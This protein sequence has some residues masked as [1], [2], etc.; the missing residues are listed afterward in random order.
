[1]LKGRSPCGRIERIT[2]SQSCYE[3]KLNPQ[4]FGNM[5]KN[6][7]PVVI[8]YN[9][10]DHFV[11][12]I[13]ATESDYLAFKIHKEFGSLAAATLLVSKELD[14][15]TV[16][17]GAAW[18]IKAI[19]KAL[20]ENLPKIS[21]KA[22]NYYKQLM[23]NTSIYHGPDVQEA[24]AVPHTS[25]QSSS[26]SHQ[27]S[28]SSTLP[29]GAEV[30]EDEDTEQQGSTKGYKCAECGKVCGRKPDLRGHLWS[31]HQIGEPIVC[32]LGNCKG[33][34]FSH[35]SSLRQHQRTQHRGEFR[36]TCEHCEYHTDNNGNL[37][38]HMWQK[39]KIIRKNDK[40]QPLVHPC[41]LCEKEFPASHLLKKHVKEQNCI[42]KKTHKCPHCPRKY[43]TEEGKKYHIE[44]Y[45]QGKKHPC[46]HCG[47]L[48]AAKSMNNHL[49][50]HAA[51]RAANRLLQRAHEVKLACRFNLKLRSRKVTF[52]RASAKIGQR[53]PRP[54][55]KDV[56]IVS[57]S[58]S[59]K[60]RKSKS[61]RCSSPHKK[62]KTTK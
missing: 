9:G 61:P 43:K 53:D 11:P 50:I 62:P 33:K 16:P 32:N 56:P 47:V 30:E 31:K 19:E 2:A 27:P 14:R 28:A 49:R 59:A 40:G 22:Y 52:G 36:F 8:A 35:E 46:P 20:E 1:M 39:H 7:F 15:P 58:A 17:A 24:P 29:A 25:G 4:D 34:S 60:L 10:R 51:N 55:D 21:K 6:H 12:T 57:R 3:L 23:R 37:T 48:F 13:P 42:K 5:P 38:S 41:K 45:H 26:A 18:G 54:K 44:H